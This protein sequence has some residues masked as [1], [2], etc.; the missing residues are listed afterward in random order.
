MRNST[1]SILSFALIAVLLG[2]CNTSSDLTST[3]VLKKRRYTKGY[4]VNIKGNTD[5]KN[6]SVT[7]DMESIEAKPVN[8]MPSDATAQA[9][10]STEITEADLAPSP[11]IPTTPQSAKTVKAHREATTSVAKT[12]T[13]TNKKSSKRWV[14]KQYQTNSEALASSSAAAAASGSE[15][16]ALYVILAIL[17]PPLAVG[18]LYGLGGEFWISLILTLIFYIPG[19][20]Y[21]LIK[22]FQKF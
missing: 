8:A 3:S 22:V 19:L 2:S 17:L 9:S 20:I 13:K 16:L 7:A 10:L 21:S 15:S 12:P 1:L 6:N 11:I 4:Q 5:K 14:S 18:L